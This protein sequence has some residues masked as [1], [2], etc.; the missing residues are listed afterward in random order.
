MALTGP[1]WN[2]GP[3][4]DVL[5]C[6]GSGFIAVAITAPPWDMDPGDESLATFCSAAFFRLV[7]VFPFPA[8]VYATAATFFF[9]CCLL[10]M[11]L[12]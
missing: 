2:M 6:F 12:D 11:F 9:P 5:S 1:L 4:D 8:F 7:P 3:A 10:R